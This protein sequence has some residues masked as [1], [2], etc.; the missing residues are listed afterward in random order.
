MKKHTWFCSVVTI[1][2]LCMCAFAP[3][4]IMLRSQDQADIDRFIQELLA[5]LA[6]ASGEQDAKLKLLI[7]AEKDAEN[8][9][10]RITATKQKAAQDSEDADQTATNMEASIN[11]RGGALAMDTATYKDYER[12]IQKTVEAKSIL[13]TL[14]EQE[15]RAKKTFEAS[16]RALEGARQEHFA[17]EAIREEQREKLAKLYR[18]WQ[19]NKGEETFKALTGQ[20]TAMAVAANETS[21]VELVTQGPN[22]QPTIGALI[23]YESELDRKNKIQPIKSSSCATGCVEKNMPKGWYYMWAMRGNRETSEKTRYFHIK[24]PTDRAEIIET[25]TMEK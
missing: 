11:K 23:Y 21:D 15:D 17:Q 20:L 25:I 19:E 6:A 2:L 9:S 5:K 10:R 22:K 4:G 18:V 7:V 13:T 1:S 12:K 3:Q 16:H 8:Y 24:G 14:A